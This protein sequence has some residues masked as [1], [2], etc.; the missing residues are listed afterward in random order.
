[1]RIPRQ[2]VLT[3]VILFFL[4]QVLFLVNIQFPRTVDFDEFHYVP[5]AKQF[6]EL[7]ENQN[8]EHPP[9]GKLIMAAGIK[10]WGDRPIGWRY[11]STVFGSL[12]LVGM[13]ILGWMLFVDTG[14]ALWAALLT[15]ANHLLYVQSRIG[16]LDTFMVGFLI[17]AL[18]GFCAAWNPLVRKKD[19]KNWL[20]FSGVMFGLSTACKWF[21]VVPWAAC[22]G[23]VVLL[24]LREP[25]PEENKS[26]ESKLTAPSK[27]WNPPGLWQDI[28]WG[29]LALSLGVI[30][31]AAYF[32][33][34]IPFLFI[35]GTIHSPLDF[36]TMQYRMWDGQLRVVSS[37]PYMSNWWQWP[38]LNRPIWYAFDHD[39]ADFVRGVILLG[40]PLIMW[41]GLLAL[42]VCIWDL[43]A[44]RNRD[45]FLITFFYAIFYSCWLIIPRKI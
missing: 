15:L 42:G 32:I 20:A 18:V 6:L 24:R 37:H 4:S 40:N 41:T 5:S 23:L 38:L 36:L 12:T 8:W 1:V 28:S 16:M 22:A 45:A 10:T 9:L 26:K 34:F 7:R 44:H 14:I 30:P 29:R 21:S 27:V 3:S 33:T 19:V 35:P 25:P 2:L 17:W 31:V 43:I 13:Y 39:G 11:M